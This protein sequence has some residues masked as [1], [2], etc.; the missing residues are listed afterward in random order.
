MT[1]EKTETGYAEGSVSRLL[2]LL[3]SGQWVRASASDSPE[4]SA[5]LTRCADAC[6]EINNMR[7]SLI[8]ERRQALC[9]LLGKVGENL[10][11]HSPFSCDFGFNIR[12]GDNFVG[13][14][15]LTILDEAEVIIGNN[16][17]IGPNCSLITITHALHEDQRR[18]GL[19]KALPITIGD[20]VWI[21]ANVVVLPGAEIGEGAVIGAGSVVTGP[22]PAQMLAVG[23]PC[24]PVRP[25]AENDRIAFR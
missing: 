20:N 5:M 2:E 7:P 14:F 4:I 8:A 17:M 12:I 22:V 24:R 1:T 6:F 15:N 18:E 16:V 19:M 3:R 23:N 25:V 21:A 10:V 9:G 11:I 13:N